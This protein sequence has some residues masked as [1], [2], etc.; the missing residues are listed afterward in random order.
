MSFT[1]SDTQGRSLLLGQPTKITI[2]QPV[3][4]SVVIGVPPMH[5]D[6]IS[7]DPL[8]GVP[9]QV[10]NLSAVPDGF[11]T[12][13]D[14]ENTSE[15]QSGTT[16]TTSWSYGTK[17]T[18]GGSVQFGDPDVAEIKVSDMSTAAQDMKSTAEQ[19]QG[20]YTRNT[21]NVYQATGL[22]DQITY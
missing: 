17:T 6:W 20:S 11:N 7:P 18:V 2:S 3:Q 14:V 5:V 8:D 15:Q 21:Y 1:P 16:N 12:T 19:G 13:Y 22:G 9:A 4:P 10:I